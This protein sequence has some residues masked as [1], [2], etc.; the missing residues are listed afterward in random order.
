MSQCCNGH[1][2]FFVLMCQELGL[3]LVAPSVFVVL[4]SSVV[5]LETTT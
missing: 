2:S 1:H 3:G 5:G 4:L